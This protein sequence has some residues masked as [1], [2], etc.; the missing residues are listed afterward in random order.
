MK[1]GR[2]RRKEE[3]NIKKDID[4]TEWESVG[5]ICLTNN[6][7]YINELRKHRYHNKDYIAII[8]LL[9]PGHAVA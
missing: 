3:N 2:P 4:E 6:E 7:E 8:Y 9:K 1:I 5:F